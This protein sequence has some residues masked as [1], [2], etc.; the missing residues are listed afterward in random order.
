MNSE[1][2]FDIYTEILKHVKSI[3]DLHNICI[4]NKSLKR[5]CDSHKGVIFSYLMENPDFQDN[6]YKKFD[7][8]IKEDILT[9]KEDLYKMRWYSIKKLLR[10]YPVGEFSKNRLI[11]TLQIDFLN[12]FYK[13][14]NDKILNNQLVLKDIFKIL[15]YPSDR[16][17]YPDA[18]VLY[19]IDRFISNF[20]DEKYKNKM[21]FIYIFHL[22]KMKSKSEELFYELLDELLESMISEIVNEYKVEFMTEMLNILIKEFKLSKDYID[23]IYDRI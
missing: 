20:V 13:F 21:V 9:S 16:N 6:F 5:Y 18:L 11:N 7:S 17:V 19:R 2:P 3:N 15:F 1:L 10:F 22:N 8:L 14:T 4:M 23:E 12:A